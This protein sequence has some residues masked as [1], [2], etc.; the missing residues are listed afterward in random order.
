[1]ADRDEPLYKSYV[2]YELPEAVFEPLNHIQYPQNE[3]L[4]RARSFYEELNRR[5][6][7]RQFS[8]EPVPRELIEYAI[9]CGGTAPSGAHRQPW[10]FVAVDDPEL[11][12][13]I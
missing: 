8:S 11:K 4:E 12:R 2:D 13:Q 6:T 7:T 5:R 9:L 3:M 1:M 10:R